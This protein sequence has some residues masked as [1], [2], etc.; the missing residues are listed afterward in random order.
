M[1]E[2]WQSIKELMPS[3]CGVGEDSE[4]RMDCEE[5]KPVNHK[6]NQL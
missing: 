3:N 2:L 4:S 5:I 1:I 6:G